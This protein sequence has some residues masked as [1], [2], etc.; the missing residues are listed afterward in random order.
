VNHLPASSELAGR[1]ASEADAFQLALQ[2][3]EAMIASTPEAYEAWDAKGLALAGLGRI[4]EGR[5]A[6]RRARE[7]CSDAGV[8]AWVERLWGI[9]NGPKFVR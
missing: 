5:A 8:V 2:Q 6:Y 4:E 7:I 1:S 3:A 9:L